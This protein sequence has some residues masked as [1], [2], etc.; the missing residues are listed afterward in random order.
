MKQKSE[1][2]FFLGWI[3]V[4]AGAIFGWRPLSILVRLWSQH[5]FKPIL[6][7]SLPG[8][9]GRNLRLSL[10]AMLIGLILILV[11]R[12][13]EKSELFRSREDWAFLGW[14]LMVAGVFFGW[15]P[16]SLLMKLRG[17]HMLNPWRS[18]GDFGTMQ[19]RLIVSVG[20][21]IAGLVLV[22]AN[23]KRLEPWQTNKKS[24]VPFV[25]KKIQ[26]MTDTG[27]LAQIQRQAPLQEVRNAASARMKELAMALLEQDDLE[28]IR[29]EVSN[30]VSYGMYSKDRTD[31]LAAAAKK[32][33]EI[34]REFW[35][36]LQSWA[37]TDSKSH[38]DK[39]GGFH[40]D[41]TDYYDY[42]RYPDGRTVANKNGR[43]RHTD[44]RGSYSDCHDDR[45]QDHTS[46]TDKANADKLE[47]FKPWTGDGKTV[48]RN[49]QQDIK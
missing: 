8:A 25:Q 40:T 20:A 6:I 11:N 47:R 27:K 46:H 26:S 3:L 19:L 18:L 43:R 48:N 33:P 35:P 32:H 14:I 42:F 28:A 24:R 16:F 36:R 23:R 17:K 29:Q 4:I 2:L 22:L 1:A 12:Q 10:L 7:W 34:V 5:G 37:H 21:V 41:R 38:S 39:P 31:F 44:A 9:S 13:K 15:K 45:H 30:V 49:Q